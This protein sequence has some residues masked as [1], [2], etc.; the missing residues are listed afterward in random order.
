MQCQVLQSAAVVRRQHVVLAAIVPTDLVCTGQ[1]SRRHGTFPV[2]DTYVTLRI[3]NE[4]S[5]PAT[6]SSLG[7]VIMYNFCTEML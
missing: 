6:R 5:G 4:T 3:C 2:R 1:Y 7:F